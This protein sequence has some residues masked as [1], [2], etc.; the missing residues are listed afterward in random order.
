MT[1]TAARLY[2]IVAPHWQH[3]P[4]GVFFWN[5]GFCDKHGYHNIDD[6]A[7]LMFEA[8]LRRALDDLCAH[9]MYKSTRGDW[10]LRDSI[11]HEAIG[12]G[13]TRIEA[14]AAALAEKEKKG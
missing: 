13:P 11:D 8:M 12:R 9:A 14:L 1:L 4:I 6:H 7:E 10:V 5:G 3:W 2:E